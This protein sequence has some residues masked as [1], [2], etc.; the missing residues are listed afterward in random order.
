M[1]VIVIMLRNCG[2]KP[3]EIPTPFEMYSV[4]IAVFL[5]LIFFL[6]DCHK[7]TIEKEK[8][9]QSS[10]RGDRII[11]EIRDETQRNNT[12]SN[13]SRTPNRYPQYPPSPQ[14]QAQ[15]QSRAN[16]Q[17]NPP[18]PARQPQAQPSAS[19]GAGIDIAKPYDV[20]KLMRNQPGDFRS[21]SSSRSG[22]R[23]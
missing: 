20:D 2:N 22:H 6:Y 8:E 9:R 13:A 14:A 15:S 19:N 11:I 21:G 10:D 17:P 3:G 1:W 5:G 18:A 4:G 12:A 16:S 7:S 23:P